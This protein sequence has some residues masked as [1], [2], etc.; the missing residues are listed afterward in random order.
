MCCGKIFLRGEEIVYKSVFYYDKCCLICGG[1]VFYDFV[2]FVCFYE[3]R[4]VNKLMLD[5]RC[6]R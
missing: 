4:V 1:G 6:G 2:D 3:Y 5:F